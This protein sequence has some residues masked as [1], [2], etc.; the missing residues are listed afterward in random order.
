[1]KVRVDMTMCEDHGQCAIAAPDVFRMNDE[2]K[3]EYDPNP[4]TRCWPRSRKPPMSAPR[5]RSSSRTDMRPQV[6]VVG[7][8]WPAC[9]PLSNCGRR[10]TPVTSPSWGPK[11]QAVQPS[12][13][14][15]G[16]A[17]RPRSRC[18]RRGVVRVFGISSEVQH[19]RCSV[20]TGQ[21]GGVLGS[22]RGFAEFGQRAGAGLRC[23][24][25]GYR[26]AATAPAGDTP[27]RGRHVVRTVDDAVS[28]RAA[29]VPAVRAVV[30][31]GGFIGSEV[32]STLTSLGARVTVVE[33]LPVP[34]LRGSVRNSGLRCVLTTNTPGCRSSPGKA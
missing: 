2:S 1:M 30:V 8:S 27:T 6:V 34:M 5:R 16:S 22:C 23:A 25:G 19:R 12:A 20:A 29:L 32:A 10:D 31:G 18:H 13:S 28:L 17:V 26:L 4:T 9:A 33:P 24:R 3:L 11:A 21:P 14:V 7:A 15:E